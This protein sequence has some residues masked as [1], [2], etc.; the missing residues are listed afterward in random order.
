M[1][2]AVAPPTLL[3]NGSALSAV[4]GLL[5]GDTVVM[6]RRTAAELEDDDRLFS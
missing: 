4:E 1:Y 6:S 5:N 2:R 3:P